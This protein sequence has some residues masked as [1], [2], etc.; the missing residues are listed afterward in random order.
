MVMML[1]DAYVVALILIQFAAMCLPVV[2]HALA[3]VPHTQEARLEFLALLSL[4]Q[5]QL[6]R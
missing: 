2:A 1:C 6:L 5:D 3:P 4:A